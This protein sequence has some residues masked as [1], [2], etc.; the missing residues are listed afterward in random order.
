VSYVR[1]IR[2]MDANGIDLT[3]YEIHERRFF[4]KVRRLTLETGE[5]VRE[6]EGRLVIVGTGEMLTRV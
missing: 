2:V 6:V 1:S 4:R 3:L 5:I